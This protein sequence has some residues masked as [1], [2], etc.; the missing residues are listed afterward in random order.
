MMSTNTNQPNASGPLA[1][2]AD[3]VGYHFEDVSDQEIEARHFE[4]TE[5]ASRGLNRPY[6]L[7]E[8]MSR[9]IAP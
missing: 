9:T 1:R 8:L 6:D 3:Y 2:V 5:P 4:C 7:S